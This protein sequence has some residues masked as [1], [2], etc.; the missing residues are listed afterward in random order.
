MGSIIN[1][2][3]RTEHSPGLERAC[4]VAAQNGIPIAAAAGNQGEDAKN[5]FPCQ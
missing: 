4:S 5:T 1:F 2:S 3:G